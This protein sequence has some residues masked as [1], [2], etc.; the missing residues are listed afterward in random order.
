MNKISRRGFF[1]IPA[2]SAASATTAIA[3]SAMAQPVVRTNNIQYYAC[4]KCKCGYAMLDVGPYGV[5]AEYNMPH[6][7]PNSSYCCNSECDLFHVPFEMPK[8]EVTEAR[9]VR[10]H[11]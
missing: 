5:P 9:P 8:I 1:A 10:Y 7:P 11:R 2:A 6:I 3:A 4:L